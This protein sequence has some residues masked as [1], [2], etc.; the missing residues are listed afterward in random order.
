MISQDQITVKSGSAFT[1]NVQMDGDDLTF[2]SVAGN[3]GVQETASVQEAASA[4]ETANVQEKESLWVRSANTGDS[5]RF[6]LWSTLFVSAGALMG[7]FFWSERKRKI[8]G[9]K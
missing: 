9:G 5:A 7:A 1:M 8:S 3:P 4:Q 6:G 2:L